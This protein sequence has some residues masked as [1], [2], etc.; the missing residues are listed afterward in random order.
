M[1]RSSNI[2]WSQ[3]KVGVFI[4]IALLFFAGGILIMGEKTKFFTPKGEITVIMN[5]AAGLK[6]GAPANK[7][8]STVLR[9]WSD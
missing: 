5:D 8:A 7:L 9:H 4:V 1:K 6:P 3:I 2:C